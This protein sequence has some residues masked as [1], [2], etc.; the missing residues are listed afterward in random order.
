MNQNIFRKASM[1]KISSPEQLNDYIRISRPGIWIALAAAFVLLASVFIWSV[2]GSLSVSVSAAGIARGG[3][4]V[5]YLPPEEAEKLSEGMTAEI[6]AAG[7]GS[8]SAVARTPLSEQEAAASVEGDYAVYALK[9]GDWNVPVSIKTDAALE[10]GQVY[11][12][13]IATGSIRP[14]AFLLN[15]GTGS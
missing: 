13:S 2:T 15:Q 9:L 4:L 1:E 14:A 8:V 7:T 6:E 5:C 12:V 3:F 10:E 11:R